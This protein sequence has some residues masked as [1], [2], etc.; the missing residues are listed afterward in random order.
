MLTVRSIRVQEIP[1]SALHRAGHALQRYLALLPTL[2]AVLCFVVNI[3][4]SISTTGPIEVGTALASKSSSNIERR[5]PS[6][7]DREPLQSQCSGSALLGLVLGMRMQLGLK[8]LQDKMCSSFRPLRS[9]ISSMLMTN[10]RVF[11]GLHSFL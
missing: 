4:G 5:S 11:E 7:Q 8:E 9:S 1:F 3:G 6:S 10:S 2:L